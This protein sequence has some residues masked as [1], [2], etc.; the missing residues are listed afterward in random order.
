MNGQY[1]DILQKYIS[2]LWLIKFGCSCYK[3]RSTF[4]LISIASKE[5]M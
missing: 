4:L 1:V 5:P 3:E 2:T